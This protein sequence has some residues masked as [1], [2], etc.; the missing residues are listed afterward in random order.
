LQWLVRLWQ[1]K[2]KLLMLKLLKHWLKK[3]DA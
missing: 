2:L 3:A 1:I